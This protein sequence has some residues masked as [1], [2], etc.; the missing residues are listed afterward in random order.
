MF[1][2]DLETINVIYQEFCEAYAAG[3]YHLDRLKECYNGD[4]DEKELEIERQHVHI[5]DHVNKNP[6]LDMIKYITTNYKGK[7]KYFKDKNG[8]FKIPSYRYQLIGHNASG[9]DNAIVLNSLSKEYTNKNTNIIR[10]SRGFLNISFRVG[11][12]YEDD[13]EIPQYM[14]FVCSKVHISA[15]LRKI[16]KEYNIQQQLIKSEIDHNLITLSNYKEH[17]GLWK[18]YLT[19]DVLGLVAVVAKHGNKIQQLTCVSFENSLTESS[20]AWSTLGRYIKQSAKTFY[21][22]KKRIS[23]F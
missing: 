5:F 1:S 18:P 3:C 23:M 7:P 12:V 10:I 17:E 6:V 8:D 13:R 4:L 9:F 2:F 11:T 16:Q 22:P 14:K 19:D 15:S 20:L 21:T